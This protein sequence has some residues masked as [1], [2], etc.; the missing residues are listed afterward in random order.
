MAPILPLLHELQ[1]NYSPEMNNRR[2]HLAPS[3][4]SA[5]FTRLGHDVA[6]VEEGGADF[7]HVDVMDGHFVPNISIGPLVVAAL[8]RI[9]TLPLD[10]H[11]MIADP[12]RYLE[13]FARAGAAYITVH[14]EA[15]VHLHR[16][17]AQIRRLGCK[18]GVTLNPAT[19]LSTLEEILPDVDMVLLM[20]VEPGFGGQA[21]IPSVLRRARTVR[22]MLDECGNTAC[23]IE[24][25]G[26]IKLD[27]VAEV[28]ATG[29][30][31]IVSGS[32]VFDT[33]DPAATLRRMR[34]AC[35]TA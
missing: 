2:V 5:D 4:L 19:S 30:D 14:V 31:V 6:R 13:E 25:D 17:V 7:L 12:D 26:G 9:T 20:S 24:A 22:R 23:L 15:A 10:C 28:F 35:E 16:T 1:E 11:L 33:P 21:F 32:G 8:K 34:E 27:N 29:V 3:L 18:A